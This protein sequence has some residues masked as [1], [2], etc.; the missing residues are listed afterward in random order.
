VVIKL[1]TYESWFDGEPI[2]PGDSL[3]EVLKNLQSYGYQGLQ[4]GGRYRDL[5]WDE[6]GRMVRDS[7]VRL[8]VAGGHGRLLAREPEVRRQ[9]VQ[10]FKDAL[11]T[12]ARLGA[13]GALCGPGGRYE[14][15]APA[16]PRTIYE[17]HEDL[18]I[19]EL[20]EIA[21]VAEDAG[22]MLILEPINRYESQFIQ[23]LDQAH[24]VCAAVG[25]PNVGLMADL[26]HM[27]IEEADLGQAIEAARDYIR[28]VHLADSNRCEPGSGHLDYRPA[29][30]ALKRIGYD[31]FM[32]LECRIM[33]ADKGQALTDSARLI[34]RIWDEV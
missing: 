6:I 15:D 30:A 31:G 16:P 18:L 29:L 4:I 34:R 23:R 27:N 7:G 17:L 26:F 5:D 28:Y 11:R 25:S 32:T 19:E 21:P 14:I 1:G 3:P 20:R 10:T 33:G 24:R 2:V 22:V 13:I 8:C 9:A 12:A